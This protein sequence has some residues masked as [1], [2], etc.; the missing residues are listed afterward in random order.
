MLQSQQQ[1][2]PVTLTTRVDATNL[3][4]LRQQFKSANDQGAIPSYSDIIMKLASIVLSQHPLLMSQW[5]G[6][7]LVIPEAIH[8][9]VAVDTEAGLLVP[10]VRDVDQ[11]SLLEVSKQ[12]AQLVERAR[13]GQLKAPDL[14]GGVF[15]ITNLGSYGIDAFTPIINIPE[16][17]ILGLGRIRREPAVY[18]N[19]I[20]PRDQLSLSLTFDHRIVDGAPAARFLQT[21]GQAIE[22]PSAWLLRNL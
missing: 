5:V 6:E 16:T 20:V 12:S 1:T 2:A 4:S 9:G 19:Q 8:I 21:L 7:Q 13:T 17:A 3:V 14:Q 10:V 11:L 18:E 15:T 22:T